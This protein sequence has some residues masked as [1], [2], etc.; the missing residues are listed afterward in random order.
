LLVLIVFLRAL[1]WG[2][3]DPFFSLYLNQ[4]TQDYALIGLLSSLVAFTALLTIIPLMRLTDKIQEGVLIRDGQVLYLFVLFSYV[5]GGLFLNFPLLIFGLAL[6]GIAQT[7]IVVGVEAY[8]RKHDGG[9]KSGPFGFYTAMDYLGWVLGML[10]A[11]FLVH[12]YSLNSMFLFIL[13]SIFLSFLI[14]PQIHEHGLRSILTGFKRY[15]HKRQDFVDLLTDFRDLNPKM[16][17]LLTLAFFDGALRMFAYVF[18]PLFAV[19]LQLDLKAI[20]LLMVVMNAPYIFSYFFSEI[21]DVVNKMKVI[22]FGLFIGFLAFL[23]LYTLVNQWWVLGLSALTSLSIAVIRPAYNGLIT[24]FTPRGKTGEV[25]GIYNFV[26]RIGRIVGPILT[27]VIADAYGLNITFLLIA[28]IS[29]G[30][31]F[32]SIALRG[33]DVPETELVV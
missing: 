12:L 29:L 25:T 3:A 32:I 1:G 19:S 17:F 23:M 16:V 14:L 18:I 21:S 11:A 6:N 15:F 13:P 20:A 8:I 30:L 2:F 4:F 24:K 33:Y 5:L 10:A 26:D 28:L 9:G 27:G 31:G 22:A 7:L